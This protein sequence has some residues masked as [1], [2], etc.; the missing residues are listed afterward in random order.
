MSKWFPSVQ[1]IRAAKL[2]TFVQV[3]LT[4]TLFLNV[5]VNPSVAADPFRTK[6][7]RNIGDKTEAAFKAIFQQGDYKAAE[8]YLQQA[9]ISE[10]NEPL[11]YAMKAS[12]AYTNKDWTTLDTYSKKTL[13]IGQKLIASDPLRG[14]IYTAVGHFLEGAALVRRQGT[15]NGATQALSKLQE[16]YKYLDKAQAISANDPELNLLK[17]YMDLMLAVNLPFANPQQ[18]IERLD[19]N[20]APEYLADRGIAYGYRDLKQYNQALEYV[21]RALKATSN[22][23]EVYYLKAQILRGMAGKEKNQQL[24][25]EAVINFD[26]ALAKKSQLPAGLVKQIERERRKAAQDIARAQR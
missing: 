2:E 20:A 18:A 26:Q 23:P 8:A 24:L 7:A 16:V 25:Q 11:A 12:L 3:S 4:A 21:N 22:N 19:K 5:W 14:N 9:L 17:G 1:A 6:E 15:V 10:P 13:E